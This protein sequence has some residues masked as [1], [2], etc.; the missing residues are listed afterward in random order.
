[1]TEGRHLLLVGGGHAHVEVLRRLAAPRLAGW[2]VTL[3]TREAM[4]PYS[5]MLPGV[6]AGLYR[7]AEALID[8]RALAAR[9]GAEVVIDRATGIDLP[10]KRLLRAEGPPIA[11]DLLS[12]DTGATPDTA[13]VA[14]AAAHALSLKPIDALLPRLRALL[15]DRGAR[16]IAVVGAGAAGVEVSLALA[17]RLPAAAVA[18]VAGAAGLLPGFPARLRARMAAALAA[19]R[20]ALHQGEDVVEVSR[21]GLGFS[22]AP[23]IAADAVLWAAGVAAPPWLA[24]TGLLR[25]RGGFLRVDACLRAAGRQDVFAA[26]DVAGFVPAPLPKAGVFAVRQGKVLA[27]TLRAVAGGGAPRAYRPQRHF[28]VLLSLG[29]GHAMGTRNGFTFGGRW[30]WWL[31]DRIDRR[32]MAR[33]QEA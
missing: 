21:E 22:R 16:R 8:V 7:E 18:L 10:A 26:G 32:F 9:C 23:P 20:V 11:W 17:A 1:M 28:L 4:S 2:R 33:Y 19:R 30:V 29:D 31:K 15:G 5:G 25:D 12:I 13:R 27:A 14:G 24:E 6:I 3:L